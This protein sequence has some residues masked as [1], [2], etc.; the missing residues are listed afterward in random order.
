MRPSWKPRPRKTGLGRITAAV[1][2]LA[3]GAMATAPAL[4]SSLTLG[5]SLGYGC[6]ENARSGEDTLDAIK[7]CTRALEDG[8]M[9]VKDTAA[10]YVNRGIL[11]VSRGDIEGAIKDY[12]R[13][14]ELKPEL[15]EAYANMG[16]AYLRNDDFKAALSQLDKALTLELKQ[17]SHVYYNRAIVYES[18]GQNE[19]A[20]EDFKQA[21]AL[22]PDWAWPQRELQRYQV[23]SH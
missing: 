1:V 5:S 10:T 12:N 11:R 2:A 22:A 19:Q 18:L 13:A 6:F 23:I 3:F 21:A 8:Q 14:L 4:A 7:L 20:Y 17:P 15:G 9:S 16:A